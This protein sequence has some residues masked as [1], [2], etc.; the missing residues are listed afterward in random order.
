MAL[1][2][3]NSETITKYTFKVFSA[4]VFV[5]LFAALLINKSSFTF[6]MYWSNETI[7]NKCFSENRTKTVQ[8]Y[9]DFTNEL[10]LANDN[11]LLSMF[12]SIG[13]EIFEVFLY[14]LYD[15]TDN[16]TILI[17]NEDRDLLKKKT[18]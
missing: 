2:D 15:C 6:I 17:E 16:S 7:I 18:S 10:Q 11:I 4:I 1:A 8:A 5:I 9:Y 13:V 3:I 12:C 14:L